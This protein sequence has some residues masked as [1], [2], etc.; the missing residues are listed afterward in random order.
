MF[1]FAFPSPNRYPVNRMRPRGNGLV[2]PSPQNFKGVAVGNVCKS[3]LKP[4]LDRRSLSPPDH[5]TVIGTTN[6]AGRL[7]CAQRRRRKLWLGIH[8]SP[9][10]APLNITPMET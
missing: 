4:G 1:T 3:L 6:S 5:N 7:P 2:F 9:S 8:Q 10:Q